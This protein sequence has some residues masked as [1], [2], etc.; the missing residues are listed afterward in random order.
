[1]YL[2]QLAE[3]GTLRLRFPNIYET[4]LKSVG[5][6]LVFFPLQAHTHAS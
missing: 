4:K 2:P 3:V 6:D 1:M 5:A